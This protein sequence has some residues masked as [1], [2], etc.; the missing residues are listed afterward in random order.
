MS[1]EDFKKFK[2]EEEK[3]EQVEETPEE[4]KE[5][6][7]ADIYADYISRNAKNYS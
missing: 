5:A 2:G 1:I 4:E 7:S 3:E 6:T